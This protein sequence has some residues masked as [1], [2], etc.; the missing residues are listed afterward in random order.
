MPLGKEAGVKCVQL[1]EDLKCA[2]FNDPSRPKVCN[3]FKPETL[4]CGNSADEAQSIFEW[5]ME[6]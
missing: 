2:V 3:N 1:T 4:F 5:L 6:K